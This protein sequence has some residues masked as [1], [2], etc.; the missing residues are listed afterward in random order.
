MKS[1]MRRDSSLAP[2]RKNFRSRNL[3]LRA[4]SEKGLDHVHHSLRLH[5]LRAFL[6]NHGGK[7][8]RPV[9]EAQTLEGVPVATWQFLD[10]MI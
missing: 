4:A 5:L 3:S 7:R 10:T 1:L 2:R 9:G 6:R 8:E